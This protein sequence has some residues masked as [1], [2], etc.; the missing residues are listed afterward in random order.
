[1]LS[2]VAEALYWMGRYVERSEHSARVLEAM[3]DLK[4]DLFE[5]DR[6]VASEQWAGALRALTL[7]DLPFERLVLDPSEPTS[8]LCSMS[9]ATTRWRALP[10]ARRHG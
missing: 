4:L 6:E 7:P 10:T 3:I 1:M 5:V 8:L 9:R 2:R